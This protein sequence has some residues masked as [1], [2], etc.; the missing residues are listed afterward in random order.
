M[1][2][3]KT[4]NPVRW[5][6]FAAAITAQT[7]GTVFGSS[8]IFTNIFLMIVFQVLFIIFIYNF[9]MSAFRDPGIVARDIDNFDLNRSD[10][11]FDHGQENKLETD[12][13]LKKKKTPAN[14]LTDERIVK[15]DVLESGRDLQDEEAPKSNQK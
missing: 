10:A 6:I 11:D 7:L 8:R 9:L 15:A 13:D 14:P 1:S 4:D 12:F 2:G 3:H 5:G